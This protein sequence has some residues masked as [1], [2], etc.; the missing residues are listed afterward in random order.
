MAKAFLPPNTHVFGSGNMWGAILAD[1]ID[2]YLVGVLAWT[3][4]AGFADL[5]DH[6][7]RLMKRRGRH[8]LCRRCNGEGKGNTD[9]QSDHC[10][11][12]S[13]RPDTRSNLR[14]ENRGA[15]PNQPE[16]RTREAG[17][18]HSTIQTISGPAPVRLCLVPVPGLTVQGALGLGRLRATTL[19]MGHQ[20]RK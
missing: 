9:Q 13:E 2:S 10:F 1:T 6:A 18:D 3:G 20:F 17:Y 16:W 15:E 19:A 5:R 11:P 12:P 14:R 7:V 8:G 4:L